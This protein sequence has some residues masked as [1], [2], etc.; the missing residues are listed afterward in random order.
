MIQEGTGITLWDG[1]VK[2]ISELDLYSQ[3]MCEDG[4]SSRITSITKDVQT[5][6]KIVQKTKHRADTGEA[7]KN[8][9]KRQI[10]YQRLEF[11]CSATHSLV[12]RTQS[13]P[14]LERSHKSKKY[15]IRWTTLDDALTPDNRVIQIPKHHH[16]YFPMNTEGKL[17]AIIFLNEKFVIDN[18]P[19]D[20]ILQVRDLDLLSTRIRLATYLKF[21]PILKGNGILSKFLTG[22]KH[23]ATSAVLNMAWLL[24]LWIGDG[25]TKEPQIT[26]DIEDQ[27]LINALINRVESWG[28]YPSY[29]PEHIKKRARH[30]KLYYGKTT[31]ANKKTRNLRKHNPFWQVVKALK[32]KTDDTGAKQIPSFMWDEDLEVREAFLAGIIDSDGY[33]KT[34]MER[35]GVYRI[36]IQTIYPSVMNGIAHIARSL[37]ISV[38]ITTRSARQEI[39]KGKKSNCKF[40]FDCNMMGTTP[41]HNVLSYCRSGKKSRIVPSSVV[42]DPIYFTFLEQQISK[43]TVYGV[44]TDS[45]KNILLDN[46]FVVKPCNQHCQH[47]KPRFVSRQRIK[48]CSSCSR[49]GIKYFYNDWTGRTKICGRC[50]GRYKFSGYHCAN[51]RYVPEAREVRRSEILGERRALGSNGE[52]V[53]GIECIKCSGVLMRDA[54]LPINN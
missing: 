8:D 16:K 32:F 48:S 20:Y 26:V 31:V 51:C 39:I 47:E 12:L 11:N 44:E 30:L 6:Y 52:Y 37:G 34:Q 18:Q 21:S 46:K 40:T 2:D 24:G 33:V 42:R 17:D 50:Y 13:K 53:T 27:C 29:V 35:K 14:I 41:M 7:S 3:V 19:L 49:K 5:T 10:V 1:S 54:T 4:T 38:T 28:I 22:R 25:T 43:G 9:P 15:R 45:N 36:A 23:L